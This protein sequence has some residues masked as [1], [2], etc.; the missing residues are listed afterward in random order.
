MITATARSSTLPLA[1]NSRKSFSMIASFG[2][3]S[4]RR[5]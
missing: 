2:Y 5:H 1:M 4:D 3:A